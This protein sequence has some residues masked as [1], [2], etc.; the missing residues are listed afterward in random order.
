MANNRL[1]TQDLL[2]EMGKGFN[3]LALE[4]LEKGDTEKAKYW[5]E[6]FIWKT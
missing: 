4:A 6:I 2:D 3:Q 1:F 5:K